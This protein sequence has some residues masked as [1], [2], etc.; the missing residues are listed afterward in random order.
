MKRFAIYQILAITQNVHDSFLSLRL[1]LIERD[2]ANQFF[3]VLMNLT[4]IITGYLLFMDN[5]CKFA[6]N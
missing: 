4:I 3:C 6:K 5:Y 2:D 1:G